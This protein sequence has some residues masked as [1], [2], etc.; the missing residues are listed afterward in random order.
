M[1]AWRARFYELRDTVPPTAYCINRVSPEHAGA[2]P[3]VLT[4]TSMRLVHIR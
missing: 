3:P 1:I 2:L 4:L